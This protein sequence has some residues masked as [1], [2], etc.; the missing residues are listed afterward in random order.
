MKI[1]LCPVCKGTGR[2][3]VDPHGIN[4][5]PDG[6]EQICHDCGRSSPDW[7]DTVEKLKD[8]FLSS[9]VGTIN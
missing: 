7:P 9:Y 8:I 3:E 6:Y 5:M 1:I 4:S 2:F